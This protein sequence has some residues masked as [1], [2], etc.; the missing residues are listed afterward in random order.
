MEKLNGNVIESRNDPEKSFEGH[1][2]EFRGMTSMS[3]TFRARHYGRISPF[4]FLYLQ[5]VQKRRDSSIQ[6]KGEPWGRLKVTFLTM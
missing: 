4:R 5:R 2:R 6:W 3:L 1:V